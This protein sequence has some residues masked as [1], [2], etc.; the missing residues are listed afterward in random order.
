MCTY[1]ARFY[2]NSIIR[3]EFTFKSF[4]GSPDTRQRDT[5]LGKYRSRRVHKNRGRVRT[6][7]RRFLIIG[8]ATTV[9]SAAPSPCRPDG[10]RARNSKIIL[11]TYISDGK[12][13][14]GRMREKRGEKI[15]WIVSERER[16]RARA[17]NISAGRINFNVAQ[18]VRACVQSL[19]RQPTCVL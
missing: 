18:C 8:K 9:R 12:K 6:S 7:H 3:I 1:A 16:E 14:S 15:Y 11:Y 2:S 17:V 13:R 19:K 4:V 10:G 5:V